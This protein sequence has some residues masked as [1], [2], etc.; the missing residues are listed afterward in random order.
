MQGIMQIGVER[1]TI[2]TDR[3]PGEVSIAELL[4]RSSRGWSM[5]AVSNPQYLSLGELSKFSSLSVKTLRS[6]LMHQAHPLPHYRLPGKILVKVADFEAWLQHYRQAPNCL[7][8][9]DHE[10]NELATDILVDLR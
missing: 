4:Y 2:P 1:R 7:L 9:L 6:Y 10:V 5:D 8:D 3:Q